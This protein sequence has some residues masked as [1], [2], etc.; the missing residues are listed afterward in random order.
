MRKAPETVS[1]LTS[2]RD[3]KI[4]FSQ[5]GDETSS[6]EA[7]QDTVHYHNCML[8]AHLLSLCICSL[9]VVYQAHVSE[10]L[11]PIESY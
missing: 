6:A 11:R 3:H 4:P 5:L 7:N 9:S 1:L 2:R 8:L 10:T